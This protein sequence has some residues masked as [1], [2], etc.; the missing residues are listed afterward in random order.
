MKVAMIRYDNDRTCKQCCKN[1]DI[2]TIIPYIPQLNER[3]ERL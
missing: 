1:I 2:D 3:A